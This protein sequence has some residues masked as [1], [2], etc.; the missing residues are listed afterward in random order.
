MN[1]PYYQDDLVTLYHGDCLEITDWLAADV[2]V[3]DPP[4][5]IDWRG[6]GISYYDEH[7]INRYKGKEKVTIRGDMTPDIRDAVLEIWEN[8]SAIVFGSWRVQRP[9]NINHLLIW[10]KLGRQ[11][12]VGNAPW[13]SNHEEIYIIGKGFVGKP[14]PTTYITSEHRP[15]EPIKWRHPTPK[16]I[17]LMKDLIR[18]CPPGVIADP[19]VGSGTT[20][21]AAKSLGRRAIGIEIEERYCEIAAKRLAQDYLFGEVEK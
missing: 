15:L 16:P 11:P 17:G 13:Y 18:K 9:E 2:M 1:K 7:G 14:S 6:K 8:R 19:F 20:L 10:V 21:V 12:G 4:Y 3:T 5:G